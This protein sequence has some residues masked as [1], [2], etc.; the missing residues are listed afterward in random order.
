MAKVIHKRD[1]R[2]N[3]MYRF[4]MCGLLEVTMVDAWKKVTC[5]NCLRSKPR[6]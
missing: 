2:F 1:V 4:T 3:Y 6:A 5:K